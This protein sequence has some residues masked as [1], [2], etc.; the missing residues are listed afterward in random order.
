MGSISSATG[1]G[2]ATPAPGAAVTAPPSPVSTLAGFAACSLWSGLDVAEN[3]GVV[4][5]GEIGHAAVTAGTGRM[6][7][8]G[9]AGERPMDRPRGLRPPSGPPGQG[10]SGATR[11]HWSTFPCSVVAARMGA[12]RPAKD[13]VLLMSMGAMLV[14]CFKIRA[15]NEYGEYDETAR[16]AYG[17]DMVVEP[18]RATSITA[19][20]SVEDESSTAVSDRFEW[21]LQYA[22][23]AGTIDEAVKDAWIYSGGSEAT[24]TLDRPGT[25]YV[26]SVKN[27]DEDG[28][29]ISDVSIKV[30]CKYV[31]REIRD[32]TDDDREAF[33]DAL[34][35]W[36]TIPNDEGRVKYGAAFENYQR[37]TVL[38][39]A[40]V[41]FFCY[42]I[43][44]QF[45]TSHFA[46]D[47]SME[48][49]LQMINPTVSL[50]IWDF[51]LDS[52]LLGHKWYNSV[53][54]H[55]DWLGSAFGSPHNDF[56]LSEG[57]FANISA[58]YDPPL[59][60]ADASR[61]LKYPP[62]I[63]PYHDPYGRINAPNNY[64]DV[65]KLSRTSTFCGLT[66]HATISTAE[67][68]VACFEDSDTVVDWETCMENN[69]HGDLHGLLGG[70]FHCNVDMDAF[71]RE[72]P[73][74]SPS[75]LSFALEFMTFTFWPTNA[76]LPSENLCNTRCT[77]RSSPKK[78]E[79]GLRCGCTCLIDAFKISDDEV[80]SYM[81]NFMR[82]AGEKFQGDLFID[83]DEDAPY[84]YG[85]T[86]ET[87]RL[88][89]E[90]SLLLMRYLV[91]I[92]CEPGGVGYLSTLA[93]PLDPAFFLMHAIFNKALHLLWL[94]PRYNDAYDWE[95]ED[96]P[97]PGSGYTDEL[98]FSEES[99]GLGTGTT[100]MTNERILERSSGHLGGSM[101]GYMPRPLAPRWALAALLLVM[102]QWE[103]R[104][105][106]DVSSLFLVLR[107][108]RAPSPAPSMETGRAL[109][110]L[111]TQ[112]RGG[113]STATAAAVA[114]AAGAAD[115]P[116]LSLP[117]GGGDAAGGHNSGGGLGAPKK[118][119]LGV[120]T[121]STLILV[122]SFLAIIIKL[123]QTGCAIL[124]AFLQWAVFREGLTIVRDE[125]TEVLL[126][127]EKG[128]GKSLRRRQWAVFWVLGLVVYGRMLV[129]EIAGVANPAPWMVAFCRWHIPV[130]AALYV[131]LLV[132]FISSLRSP[133][134]IMYQLGQLAAAHLA[135][136]F[137]LPSALVSFAARAGL[138][139]FVI[140]SASVIINDIMAYICGR[141]FGRTPLTVLSPKKTREGFVGAAICTSVTGWLIGRWLIGVDWLVTPRNVML[142][143][144][145]ETGEMFA[146]SV[147]LPRLDLMVSRAEIHAF[148]IALMASLIGPFGGFMAS[149]V[150]RAYNVKD[151]G[152]TIPGHGGAGDRPR[153]ML[154]RALAAG[155]VMAARRTMSFVSGPSP[156]AATSAAR[157]ALSFALPR[158]GGSASSLQRRQVASA[159]R[160]SL[161]MVAV[162]DVAGVEYSL[163]TEDG[164]PFETRFDQGRVKLVVGGGGFAPFL[165]D[166]VLKMEPGE[167]KEVT[168]QPKDAFGEYDPELT[169][170]L[171]MD[172]APGDISV[173]TVLQLWTGQKATV[174]EV[175]GESFKIDWNPDQAGTSLVMDVKVLEAA[176][177]ESVLKTATFAGGCFWG[178]E[179]AFQR[180]K[181]VVSTKAGYA[182]GSVK[183]PTYSQV[184]SGK[185][186]HTE[187]VQVLYDP[188]E[189]TYENLLRIFFDRHDPTQ[190]NGQGNDQGTQYRAG[191]Y[192]HDE[193]QRDVAEK[194][195]A[196]EKDARRLKKIATELEE[197]R[198]FYDAEAEH[199]QYL[200]RGGQDARKEATETIRCYG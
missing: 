23:H 182:Q 160:A 155:T 86:Q 137:V 32:L 142:L 41:D 33:L 91:K 15:T 171:G 28:K 172:S 148:W 101:S 134:L 63:H 188:S 178:L 181:G 135:A 77:S 1:G 185:T 176:K 17:L 16:S 51:M 117:V 183:K 111:T 138:Y 106:E 72:H 116:T 73:E 153:M 157:R 107:H 103:T 70:A 84:P 195:F 48:R 19:V 14:P 187:A 20:H 21:R 169:A 18:F 38:H 61:T 30:S 25:L 102:T 186:G 53:I 31:R 124:V 43:G 152:D 65:P 60:D 97:C 113:A 49:N 125:V 12:S 168:V 126:E 167:E 39:N 136:F 159:S 75:L 200:Q 192:F 69:V 197:V 4:E 179:L 82:T 44:L 130:C 163:R 165:H 2:A 92:G 177:A 62:A 40:Q 120:R 55:E 158:H 9:N 98:P 42:H 127:A 37:T 22:S 180:A 35:I 67:T 154:K 162:G 151:F 143:G 13:V 59:D 85:F 189:T 199:Q 76:F 193:E 175:S 191:V 47:L 90:E 190:V 128:G 132:Q 80:Y 45:L 147:R 3:R 64:Q 56:M 174:T 146:R 150:K 66:S 24:V 114:G 11:A 108:H 96:G 119:D 173:G 78:D 87:G 10:G 104:A 5:G 131:R 196:A 105:V 149:G 7:L 198:E 8:R 122:G 115:R 166:A 145:G 95:W 88:S 100:F 164:S 83:F 99:L 118:G 194:F 29:V 50:P 144:R 52:S 184:C 26:L 109:V 170:T 74:F 54:F 133:P 68:F 36:Y 94:S 57:R 79:D 123:K 58:I 93:S 129:K 27:V 89:D 112:L 161:S 34:Q 156:A 141:L 46:F 71:S 6:A 121:R 110:G 139:W 140:A 81:E